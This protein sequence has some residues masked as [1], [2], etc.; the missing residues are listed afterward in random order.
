GPIVASSFGA[1]ANTTNVTVT[2]TSATANTVC[3]TPG[4]PIGIG[5]TGTTTNQQLPVSEP[6]S[7]GNGNYFYQRTDLVIPGRGLP[8]I[9]QRSYNTLDN[10]LGPFGV[11]WTHSYNIV[12]NQQVTGTIVIKWGDGHG[13]TFTLSGGAYVPQAGVFNT[14]TKNPDGTFVLTRKDQTQFSFSAGGVL[15]SIRD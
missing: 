14:L 8:L 5:G 10:Y 11:N 13:E 2:H 3:S 1:S 15:T 9:F 12:L 4:T 6:V 7:T